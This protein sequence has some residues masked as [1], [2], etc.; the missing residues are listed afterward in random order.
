MKIKRRTAID[1]SIHFI[2]TGLFAAIIYKISANFIYVGIF[3][4]GGILIDLDHFIDHFIHFKNRFR[5]SDFLGST[6]LKSG[7]VYLFLHS[8]ELNLVI[9]LA[10]LVIKSYGLFILFLSLSIHLC[11]DNIQRRNRLTYFLIYRYYK[12]F[13]RDILLPELKGEF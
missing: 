2:S 7:K 1:L 12:E 8:W 11:I 4:V 5:L 9:L 13:D 3:M 10:A 6:Y